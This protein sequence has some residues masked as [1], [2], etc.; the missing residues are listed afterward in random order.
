M[1]EKYEEEILFLLFDNGIIEMNYCS[2]QKVARII[3]WQE[4]AK[5][6]DVKKG[7]S[8]VLRKLK[9]KGYVDFHGKSGDVVSLSRFGVFYVK[10]KYKK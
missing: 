1:L 7:F 3:K 2:I 4:I 9:S 10:G 8:S 6:D 5:K